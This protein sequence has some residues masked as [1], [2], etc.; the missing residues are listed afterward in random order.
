MRPIVKRMVPCFWTDVYSS[1]IKCGSRLGCWLNTLL[2]SPSWIFIGDLRPSSWENTLLLATGWTS[3]SR[4]L[5]RRSKSFLLVW[6][7]ILAF[8]LC[9]YISLSFSLSTWIF[10]IVIVPSTWP[11]WFVCVSSWIFIAS[12]GPGCNYDW[13]YLNSF[14]N[15]SL[16]SYTL[17]GSFASWPSSVTFMIFFSGVSMISS[18]TS[19]PFF[20]IFSSTTS[21]S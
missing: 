4:T 1:I 17:F 18:L 21:V 15:S 10:S 12:S 19:W 14:V 11:C 16:T 13:I 9:F 3:S 7:N 5:S 20:S 2:S 6:S 8:G